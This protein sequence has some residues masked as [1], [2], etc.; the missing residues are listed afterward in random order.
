MG[1]VIKL[2]HDHI[3]II[4]LIDFLLCHFTQ[5]NNPYA[6]LIQYNVCIYMY[7]YGQYINR[8]K[9]CWYVKVFNLKGTS[10][11]KN[12]G[13]IHMSINDFC[14]LCILKSSNFVKKKI[15]II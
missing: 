12:A 8:K 3:L 1:K 7:M 2:H 11:N 10:H 5:A 6:C 13:S 14:T 4:Y 9:N 15:L